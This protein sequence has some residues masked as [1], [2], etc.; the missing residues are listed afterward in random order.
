MNS[1]RVIHGQTEVQVSHPNGETKW[2]PIEAWAER[3]ICVRW[4]MSGQYDIMLKD[5]RMVARSP[6]SK[7]RYHY[8][9]WIASNLTE[10]RDWVAEQLGISKE[11]NAERYRLHNDSMPKRTNFTSTNKDSKERNRSC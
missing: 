7:R 6:Q 5:G 4:P 1:I 8:N 10:C 9:P 3:W 2:L 11:E